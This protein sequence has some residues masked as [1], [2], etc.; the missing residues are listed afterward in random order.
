[1]SN[2]TRLLPQLWLGWL[3]VA[4]ALALGIITLR[5]GLSTAAHSSAA[6][7]D[8]SST[9]EVSV[10]QPLPQDSIAGVVRPHQAVSVEPQD[11]M[12]ALRAVDQRR[13]AEASKN[14]RYW[15]EGFASQ[16]VNPSWAAAKSREIQQLAASDD[17][18]S[19]GAK[20]PVEMKVECRSSLCKVTAEFASNS[21][22]QDWV[23]IFSLTSGK[24]F[25]GGA[26]S[27]KTLPD[28]TAELTVITAARN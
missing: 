21:D 25:S 17:I 19:A 20:P 9:A 18:K 15:Q 6:I 1:M 3:L 22:A 26:T 27:V 23:E 7:V 8:T 28:G 24:A 5:N 10:D 12:A 2:K 14:Q 11:P 4:A 13:A 16:D